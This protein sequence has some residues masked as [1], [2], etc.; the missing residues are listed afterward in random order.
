M[1][2]TGVPAV[3]S[4]ITRNSAVIILMGVNDLYNVN[5]YYNYVNNKASIW[6]S[7]GASTYFVSVNPTDRSYDHLNSSINEFNSKLRRNL[8]SQVKYIDTNSYLINSGYTTVDGLHYDSTTYNKIYNYIK[9]C[10]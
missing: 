10:L 6:G 9:S 2:S 8:S 3:E 5:N 4:R 7:N 1:T